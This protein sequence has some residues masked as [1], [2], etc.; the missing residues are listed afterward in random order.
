M[1]NRGKHYNNDREY[2]FIDGG[3]LRTAV[4]N[5]GKGIL[6]ANV[7]CRPFIP[8]L[9]DGYDKIFYYDAI[10]GQRHGEPPVTY[11]ARVNSEQDRFNRIQAIN[12]VHVALG[13]IVGRD[14]RQKGVDVQ[15]AVDMMTHAFRGNIE[16]ATLLAGDGDFTPLVKALVS[17]GIHVTLWHPPENETSKELMNAADVTKLFSFA[18]NYGC[19]SLDGERSSFT[20]CA[21]IE[22]APNTTVQTRRVVGG[23]D[24]YISWKDD[25][26][27]IWR[28]MTNAEGFSYWERHCLSTVGA[29]LSAALKAFQCIFLWGI[30]TEPEYWFEPR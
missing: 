28:R 26:L 10:P 8:A 4:E 19:F 21:E 3:C 16:R 17:E 2:L 1:N 9:T 15:L 24:H 18:Q 30:P 5:I 12:R 22:E 29:G 6:G 27:T 20:Y 7:I 23:R 13:K 11:E 14:K 25:K